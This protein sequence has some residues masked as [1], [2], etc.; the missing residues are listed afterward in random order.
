[1]DYKQHFALI[2]GERA[3]N[4]ACRVKNSA[5]TLSIGHEGHKDQ[6]WTSGHDLW[7][8]RV[9]GG[10]IGQQRRENAKK[11]RQLQ[12]STLVLGSDQDYL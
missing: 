5:S 4:K 8:G 6:Y 7:A 1:V 12:G 11:K 9:T 10:E 2:A 3:N